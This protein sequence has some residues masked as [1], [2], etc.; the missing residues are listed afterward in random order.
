M[1]TNPNQEQLLQQI[2]ARAATDADFR[3]RLVKEPHAAVRESVG[4]EL[5]SKFRIKFVEKEPTL[6]AMV[7]LPDLQNESAELTE[8]EL[9]AVAG[10]SWDFCIGSVQADVSVSPT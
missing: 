1:A 3:A 10:G 9:E 8:E 4:I 2:T 7:V 6:D 5:P